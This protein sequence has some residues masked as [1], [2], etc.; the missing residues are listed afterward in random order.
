MFGGER[1]HQAHVDNADFFALLGQI[2]DR[3]DQGLGAGAD[4]DRHAL[5]LGVAVIVKQMVLPASQAG[6]CVHLRL[7]DSRQTG[8]ER[9][10]RL[11]AL[12]IHVRV[13]RRPAHDGPVGVQAALAVFAD[14]LLGDHGADVFVVDQLQLVD[15]MGGA[16]AVE[17][18]DERNPGVQGRRLGQQSHVVGLLHR[19][20]GKLGEA[21]LAH[22]GHV[23]MVAED[24]QTLRGQRTRRHV[25]HRRG[26][27]AGDLV[28]IGDHQ[29]QPLRGRERGRQRA[30][31]QRAM[32]SAGGPALALHLDDQ[33]HVAPYIGLAFRRPLVGQLGHG[34][35]RRDRVNGAHF[36]DAVGDIRHALVA[37]QS[38]NLC[39]LHLSTFIWIGT[40]QWHGRDTARSTRRS[41]CNA[42]SRIGNACP[43]PA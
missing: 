33:G 10:H 3:L 36:I 37:F 9:V 34:R 8:I 13:L 24:R 21:G 11:A 7:H 20:G 12:E 14:S 40:F 5:G 4:D 35:G 16:E 31:L 43:D 23:G 38:R 15:L 25:D 28:Q 19:A 42:R 18:M 17:E 29:Q 39:W 41:R 22:G 6:E 32:H 2:I 26:Q 30:G 27:L 1:Q